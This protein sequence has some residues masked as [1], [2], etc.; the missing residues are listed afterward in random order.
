[1]DATLP[2]NRQAI[3]CKRIFQI[4]YTPLGNVHKYKATLVVR[5]FSQI[6]GVDYGDTFSSYK[7]H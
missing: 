1:M 6:L 2:T 5:G 3:S 7:L 4:K